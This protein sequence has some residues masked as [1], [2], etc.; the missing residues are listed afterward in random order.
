MDGLLSKLRSLSYG[1]NFDPYF[2]GTLGYADDLCLLSPTVD[3]L[4]H[5]VEICTSYAEE[6]CILFDSAKSHLIGFCQKRQCSFCL[7]TVDEIYL[8][9]SKIKIEESAT[10]LGYEVHKNLKDDLD[11]V[12]RS[13]YKQYNMFRTR[14]AGVT[15]SVK[16]NLFNF[17]TECRPRCQTQCLLRT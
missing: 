17:C 11:S 7:R 12:Y 5:M 10:H 13:F 3:G 6:H 8:S 16:N 15:L 1:C 4:K 14:F 9:G 2:L